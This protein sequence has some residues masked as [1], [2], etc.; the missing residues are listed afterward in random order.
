[1]ALQKLSALFSTTT[2]AGQ[3]CIHSPALFCV[4]IDWILDHMTA[5][6]GIDIGT[7]TSTAL[8]FTSAD[9]ATECLSSFK[10][11]ARTF[12]MQI[13]WPQTKIQNLSTDSVLTQCGHWSCM[14]TVSTEWMSWFILVA[15]DGYCRTDIKRRTCPGIIRHVIV[16][17]CLL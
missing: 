14:G 3:G 13:S 11:S 5:E 10:K 9:K 6:P 12:G 1:M 7:V 16:R 15:S 8:P 2:G 17:R 4:A